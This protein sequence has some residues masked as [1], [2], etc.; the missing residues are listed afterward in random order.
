MWELDEHEEFMSYI[1]THEGEYEWREKY[2]Y[3]EFD[4]DPD[5]YESED[6]FLEALY[7]AE[8]DNDCSSV[9][10]SN[11]IQG[12]QSGDQSKYYVSYSMEENAK[13]LD[14]NEADET[15]NTSVSLFGRILYYCIIGIFCFGIF[16]ILSASVSA[17]GSLLPGI[18]LLVIMIIIIWICVS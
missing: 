6:E 13:V 11:N 14:E 16:V 18:A 4:L 2:R 7:D 5:E 15:K 8:A 9:S 12:N 10:D 17:S 1:L 3:N